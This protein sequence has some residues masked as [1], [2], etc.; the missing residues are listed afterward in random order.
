ML[1]GREYTAI[2]NPL[3][4]SFLSSN[5]NPPDEV[6]DK[7]PPSNQTVPEG[8]GADVPSDTN[9]VMPTSELLP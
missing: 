6:R 1:R 3:D 8:R 7:A 5:N 4:C 2:E 9:I